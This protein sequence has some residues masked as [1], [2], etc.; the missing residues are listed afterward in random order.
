MRL[1]AVR[2]H[3]AVP[4]HREGTAVSCGLA[5]LVVLA[6][7]NGIGL[8]TDGT[9][10]PF[11]RWL[12]NLP[13]IG[14]AYWI[15]RSRRVAWPA[16]PVVASVVVA[17]GAVVL[18][19][20]GQGVTL[21]V[22]SLVSVA[23]PWLI[24]RAL[25]QQRELV[26]RA[27]ERLE[28]TEATREA[29]A[30]AASAAIRQQL[31]ADLHDHVG[32]DLALIALQAGALEATSN[33]VSRE[34]AARLR[35]LAS[36]ATD[37]LRVVV[38]DLTEDGPVLDSVVAVAARATTAGLTVGLDGDSRHPVLV[39]GAQE[40][41]TNAARHATG[42]SVQIRA[43]PTSLLVTNDLTAT[44]RPTPGAGS[45]DPPHPSRGLALLGER[46]ASAGG[47]LRAHPVGSTWQLRIDLPSTP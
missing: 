29:Y 34:A 9:P 17:T 3:A 11:P 38:G 44:M 30:L 26:A 25:G 12:L 2:S 1:P 18:D 22:F 10:L 6:S 21:L 33:G 41:L 45:A 20:I 36:D 35:R 23:L 39:R 14:G 43:G 7:L 4:E 47:R 42:S 24:G 28:Q 16:L 27:R 15:G 40:A 19:G 31:A 46:V 8:G 5:G 32:H 13:I 37:R